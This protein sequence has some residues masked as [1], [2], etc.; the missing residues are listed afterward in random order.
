M[1]IK[2]ALDKY[3][4]YVINFSVMACSSAISQSV[5]T[6]YARIGHVAQQM[7]PDIL[8]E[9]ITIKEP[10]HRLSHDVKN[11]SYLRNNLRPDE[12]L[13]INNVT[14][15][16]Y[17]DFDIPFVYKLVRNLK[18]LPP[19]TQGWNHPNSPCLMEITAGDDL[20]RIRRLRNEILHRGN[21]QVNDTE[22]SQFFTQFKDIAGRFEKYLGKQTGDFVDQFRDLE[23]CCMDKETRNMYI[24]RLDGLRKSDEDC[25]N[26]LNDL[27][28]DVHALK[29]SSK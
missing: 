6:N 23:S 4:L 3:H 15:K 2:Y 27:E 17:A 19:P 12:W 13:L 8:Q 24:K 22:L 16:G 18:L 14:T 1:I 28:E 7:F 9:L 11:N 25:K 5:S 10:P 21:A 20:E 26:R 29:E